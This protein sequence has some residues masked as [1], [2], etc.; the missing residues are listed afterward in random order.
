MLNNFH[1]LFINTVTHAAQVFSLGVAYMPAAAG[2]AVVYSKQL[3]HTM[4]SLAAV[5]LVIAGIALIV[6]SLILLV[7][8]AKWKIFEKAKQPGWAAL[9]PVYGSV[10]MLEI[11][12]RPLWWVAL[13]MIPFVSAVLSVMT[14]YRLARNFGRGGW[15]AVG[16]VF[17]PFIFYP[18]LAFG[19]GTYKN[20]F[21]KAPAMSEAVKWSLIGLAFWGLSMVVLSVMNHSTA[22]RSMPLSVIAG[23]AGSASEYA[24]DGVY[25]YFRDLVVS[26]VDAQTFRLEGSYGISEGGVFVDGASLIG[27]DPETFQVLQGGY[28]AKDSSHAYFND[29]IISQADVQTF[30]ATAHA[31]LAKDKNHVYF[32]DR[33][34][35][36][37]DTATFVVLSRIDN[38]SNVY[39]KD[40]HIVYL[41]DSVVRGAD[42]KTFMAENGTIG[43]NVQYD[44]KD[45]KH[46]YYVGEVVK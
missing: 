46:Y 10:K 21:P 26:G 28:Y 36:G 19:K 14:V 43:K 27:A 5:I 29:Q 1:T 20:V 16:L 17:L 40:A 38:S 37:A 31:W 9:V 45:A 8:A 35:P 32:E 4:P 3:P 2:E 44:A 15:F 25:V 42:A 6:V 39:S 23:P 22:P 41:N 33:V 11:T 18:I 13:L 30:V 12:S 24:T 34:L 7:L